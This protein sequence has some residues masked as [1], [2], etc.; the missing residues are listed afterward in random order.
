M[1]SRTV[2]LALFCIA[3][4]SAANQELRRGRAEQVELHFEPTPENPIIGDAQSMPTHNEEQL[5]PRISAG[6]RLEKSSGD[7][8]LTHTNAY[9]AMVSDDGLHGVTWGEKQIRVWDLES[10]ALRFTLPTRWKVEEPYK[11]QRSRVRR[12][13][14]GADVNAVFDEDRLVVLAEKQLSVH[15]LE[16]GQLIDERL[17]IRGGK[18]YWAGPGKVAVA[19]Q[20]REC[21]YARQPGNR[22][23]ISLYDLDGTTSRSKAEPQNPSQT[24]EILG[25]TGCDLGE[26]VAVARVMPC[27]AGVCAVIVHRVWRG[28]RSCDPERDS[29]QRCERTHWSVYET[30]LTV[31]PIDAQRGRIPASPASHWRPFFSDDGRWV[32]SEDRAYDILSGEPGPIVGDMQA[33]TGEG[34]HVVLDAHREFNIVDPDQNRRVKLR[35]P[36][37]WKSLSRRAWWTEGGTLLAMLGYGDSGTT[38]QHRALGFFDANSGELSGELFPA[39]RAHYPPGTFRAF[40]SINGLVRLSAEP[41]TD[42]IRLPE[43]QVSMLSAKDGQ[44]AVVRGERELE[45]ISLTDSSSRS[46]HIPERTIRAAQLAQSGLWVA[47]SR[48]RVG[49]RRN[50]EDSLLLLELSKSTSQVLRGHNASSPIVLSS[51]FPKAFVERGHKIQAFDLDTGVHNEW[52]ESANFYFPNK[53]DSSHCSLFRAHAEGNLAAFPEV[54]VVTALCEGAL[55]HINPQSRESSVFAMVNDGSFTTVAASGQG[56]LAAGD[57]SGHVHIFTVEGPRCRSEVFGSLEELHFSREASL[58]FARYEEAIRIFN[59]ED[60]TMKSAVSWE[61]TPDF[62]TTMEALDDGGLAVGTSFGLLHFFTE[63]AP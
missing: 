5:T 1:C 19:D 43:G 47:T 37:A 18:L 17:L 35:L 16:D 10:G 12:E 38:T 57:S 24:V 51:A 52:E 21:M 25:A 36:A 33:W 7:P 15:R 56:L 54:G 20:F 46:V 48:P 42:E 2:L 61:E 49:G 59:T 11:A 28:R 30:Y 53:V 60:C 45:I 9:G 58:L 26:S 4:C 50:V 31:G 3:G 63:T 8:R 44:L 13:T 62:P 27:S 40:L 55:V 22:I 14:L 6:L 34:R 41:R 39:K 32:V 29:Q 23:F